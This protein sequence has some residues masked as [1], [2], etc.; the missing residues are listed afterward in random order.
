[1]WLFNKYKTDTEGQE[2]EDGPRA[3]FGPTRL[4]I[5][6]QVMTPETIPEFVIPQFTRQEKHGRE[7]CNGEDYDENSATIQSMCSRPNSPMLCDPSCDTLPSPHSPI[8]P[9]SPQSTRSFRFESCSSQDGDNI[10]SSRAS[11]TLPHLPI[12]SPTQSRSRDYHIHSDSS[13]PAE[14]PLICRTRRKFPTADDHGVFGGL[15]SPLSDSSEKE[16]NLVYTPKTDRK[17]SFSP[18]IKLRAF[19]KQA[20]ST[21]TE[22]PNSSPVSSPALRVRSCMT[23]LP[24]DRSKRKSPKNVRRPRSLYERRRSSLEVSLF[25][26]FSEFSSTDASSVEPSPVVLRRNSSDIGQ[27]RSAMLAYRQNMRR[28]VQ[29]HAEWLVHRLQKQCSVDFGELKFALEYFW[30]KRELKVTVL[31]AE[32]IGNQY[33]LSHNC[34]SYLKL[35]IMPGKQQRKH[36]R[37]VKRTRDPIFNEE[38]Y[39]HGLNASDLRH[40]KLRMKLFNKGSNIKRD[41]FLGE[42]QVLLGTLDFS[43]ETRMWKDLQ[44]KTDIEDLGMLNV[45]VC[46]QPRQRQIVITIVRAKDLPKNSITGAPDPYVKIEFTYNDKT[47]GHTIMHKQT[48]VRKKTTTP[49]F[50]E[51]FTFTVGNSIVDDTD[52]HVSIIMTVYDHDRIR[53]DEAIGE[54]RLGYRATEESELDHWQAIMKTPDQ[55]VPTW[56]NLM[57]LDDEP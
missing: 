25:S 44:P 22:S 17:S 30:E 18:L 37:T 26:E 2:N 11:L 51:A 42:V 40:L 46:Y 50:K 57:E 41:E 34:S 53:S 8:S 28:N 31:K 5:S 12:Y 52:T 16:N 10:E 4:K 1:M 56:H 9:Y 55:P 38:F 47:K 32:R 35:Y 15:P 21:S 3:T 36:T 14:S 19:R 20:L 24:K 49:V 7:N 29:P 43:Q 23:N 6:G 27:C 33:L 45:S 39:F 48:R 54:V 13:S